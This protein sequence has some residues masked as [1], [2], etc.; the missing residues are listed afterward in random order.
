MKKKKSLEMIKPDSSVLDPENTPGL[1]L[2]SEVLPDCIPILPVRM[3]PYFPGFTVPVS[4]T[5][6]HLERIQRIISEAD[7]TVGLIL[8]KDEKSDDSPDNLYQVGVAAKIVKTIQSEEETAHVLLNCVA[9]FT[10]QELKTD[11]NSWTA[12]VKYH[13]ESDLSENEELKAYSMAIVATLKELVQLD[14]LQSEAIKLFLS[15]S[16][17]QD[18]GK[19]ADLSATLTTASPK[20]LQEIL[21]TF[22]VKSR[23]DKA[24][25]LLRQELDMAKLQQRITDQ[26]EDKISERQREFLSSI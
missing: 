23:I 21:E 1:V 11:K 16:A 13:Q 10:I 4:V 26:I 19:L 6:D 15:H 9:R 3:R 8:V 24:L 22:D 7:E 5:G 25:L 18:P 20:S 2:V 17:M 14:P 12:L